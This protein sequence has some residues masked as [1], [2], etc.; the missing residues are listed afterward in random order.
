MNRKA[1]LNQAFIIFFVYLINIC[2]P[3]WAQS[4]SGFYSASEATF[5]M[6]RIDNFF[7]ATRSFANLVERLNGFQV[8]HKDSDYQKFV[9]ELVARI[10]KHV[11][12]IETVIGEKEIVL[13][14]TVASR[15]DLVIKFM[16]SKTHI[17]FPMNKIERERK[18]D[19]KWD[20]DYIVETRHKFKDLTSLFLNMK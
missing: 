16:R 15:G 18:Y 13:I 1:Q 17:L 12:D 3:V 5:A 14:S 9:T 20:R 2:Q 6:S 10:T 11:K 8:D 19:Y 4:C 7:I